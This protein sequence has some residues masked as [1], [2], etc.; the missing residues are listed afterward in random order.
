MNV[1]YV[2]LIGVAFTIIELMIG[3][4]RLLFS[5]PAYGVLSLAAL[6][7]LRDL[8]RPKA[9][10]DLPCLA[11]SALFFGYILARTLTS[12]VAYIAWEDRFMVIGGLM[13]YLIT[14]CYL[15]DARR[16]IWVLGI[17]LALAMVNLVVGARQFAAGDGFMLFGFIRSRQYLGRASGL[18]ICPNHLAG[19]LE[20]VGCLSASMALWSRLRAWL[21]VLFG[22]GALMC[23]AG[24]V[25]SVSRGGFIST[26]AGLAALT[27]LSLG[28]LRASAPHWLGRTVLALMVM[29]GLAGM[30]LAYVVPRNHVLEGRAQNVVAIRQDDRPKLW[31]AAV[32]QAKLA[33]LL[34][35]GSATYLYYGRM[36]RDPNIQMDPIRTHCDYLELLAEYGWVGVAGWAFFMVA[37]LRRGWLSYRY[38]SLRSD[39]LGTAAPGSNAA[40]WNI[41]A[42]AAVACLLVHSVVDFNLHIPAN[43]LLLAF[44]FGVLANPGR[45]IDPAGDHVARL[46]SLDLLPRLALPA[47]GVWIA[48]SGL[49]KLPGE[50]D[51][52]NARVALRDGHTVKALGFALHGLEHERANPMLYF[53]LGQARQNLAGNGPDTPTARSFRLAASEAYRA[54][55]RLAPMDIYLLVHEGEILTRLGDFAGA[56]EIFRQVERDDPRSGYASTYYG[57]YLQNRGLLPEAEA[58][59]RQAANSY[60]NETATRNLGE[61]ER[62]RAAGAR[63]E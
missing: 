29:L 45:R 21:K 25:I 33:P 59:Y 17:L 8:R 36:F 30:A 40:A 18:Y 3:G 39:G 14:A 46:R 38:L 63:S 32:E 50:Y 53:Y 47:L 34:G 24:I 1:F 44:V 52:E 15:T 37:H 42:L 48:V 51:S 13:L 43:T 6:A 57:F 54:G 4:T 35:T 55:L 56:E 20:V 7:S 60:P 23:F 2:V 9:E 28:R 12:P 61:I 22:Y 11:A 16:R 58:A 62:I 27:F 41:G 5:L 31:G 10:P 19:F 26:G 49:P